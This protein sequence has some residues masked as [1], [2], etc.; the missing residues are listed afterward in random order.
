MFTSRASQGRQGRAAAAACA[1]LCLS[2]C[3]PRQGAPEPGST[4][5]AP[6]GT[7]SATAPAQ[8]A[9]Q[10]AAP[11]AAPL[12]TAAQI[13]AAERARVGALERLYARGILE[14]RSKD[15]QGDHF[16][17]GDLDLRWNRTMGLALSLSKLGDRWIWIGSDLSQWWI[18]ELKSD[19]TRLRMGSLHG[20]RAGLAGAM[21]WLA[22]IR[23]LVPQEGA[24]VQP[25]EGG[26]RVP[27]AVPAGAL[28]AGAV[29]EAE[30]STSSLL[31]MR[32]LLRL[33][34]GAA[35]RMD[36]SDWGGVETEGVGPT[37][38][39]RVPKRVR[40]TSGGGERWS[41]FSMALEVLRAD[42]S[43]TD[44]PGLYDLA[45]LKTSFAPQQVESDP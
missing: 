41:T 44:K 35:W 42:A 43:T 20:P 38:W 22:G 4:T 34:D 32:T 9:T 33:Q 25:V 13:A 39:P 1:V 15:D 16:D 27:L 40:G 31:P 14:V 29:L 5:P 24:A 3:A 37:S 17:Q 23:P 36:M 12:P 7:A 21:P 11:Q 2:A 18:F 26:V 30:F 6:G 19:P 28:P 8:A 10:P 45:R